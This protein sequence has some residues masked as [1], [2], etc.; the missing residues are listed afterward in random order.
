MTPLISDLHARKFCRPTSAVGVLVEQSHYSALIVGVHHKRVNIKSAITMM[1]AMTPCS[2]AILAAKS[3]VLF[4]SIEIFTNALARKFYEQLV[5]FSQSRN[6]DILKQTFETSQFNEYRLSI[7][8][9]KSEQNYSEKEVPEKKHFMGD[10]LKTWG[11][12]YLNVETWLLLA[13]YQNFWL[14]ACS[15]TVV[16]LPSVDW[17]AVTERFGTDFF[18]CDIWSVVP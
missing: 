12:I 4:H 7:F 14:R 6:L 1:A 10:A 9:L 2:T 18:R 3:I 5:G 11:I 16:K 17:P 15:R 13:P 8:Q